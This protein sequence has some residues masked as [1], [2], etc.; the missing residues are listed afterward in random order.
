M[1]SEEGV[2]NMHFRKILPTTGKA[3]ALNLDSF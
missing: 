1:Q 2:R 3:Q